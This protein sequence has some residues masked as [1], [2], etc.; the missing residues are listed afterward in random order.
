MNS[1]RQRW[2]LTVDSVSVEIAAGATALYDLVSDL[3]R[4]GEWSPEC[5]RVEW[6]GEVGVPVEGTTFVGF[7][8]VGPGRRIKYRRHGTVLRAER[9]SG[10][11]FITDEGG[12]PSTAWH[13]HFEAV[14]PGR[15]RVT[16]GYEVRWIPLWARIIDVPLNRHQELLEGMSSTLEKLKE[17]AEA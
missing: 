16:E 4:M 14:G 2:Y 9:G 12:R 6:E 17:T 15:T 10:F 13:Y 8:E 11:S 7:N 3:P 1:G 5:V